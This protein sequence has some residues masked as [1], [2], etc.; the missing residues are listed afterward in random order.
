MQ[1]AD[2]SRSR[3][4]ERRAAVQLAGVVLGRQLRWRKGRRGTLDRVAAA[5][6]LC[7]AGRGVHVSGA[8]ADG[9][10]AFGVAVARRVAPPSP[11]KVAEHEEHRECAQSGAHADACLCAC[12]EARVA[13]RRRCWGWGTCG[14]CG[15]GRRGRG[16]GRRCRCDTSH[17]S[18][19]C[20]LERDLGRAAFATACR[21]VAAAAPGR[22]RGRPIAWRHHGIAIFI[23]RLNKSMSLVCLAEGGDS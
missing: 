6:V 16:R 12:R 7:I 14:R 4:G 3:L 17:L 5:G 13:G 21:V 19:E 9:W 2:A 11:E 8:A 1:A 15:W 10:R 18:D 23:V 20:R 22:T